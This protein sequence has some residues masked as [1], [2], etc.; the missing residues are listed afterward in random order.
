MFDEHFLNVLTF[1]MLLVVSPAHGQPIVCVWYVFDEH[2]LNVLTFQ[3]LLMV[4]IIHGGLIFCIWCGFD[5]HYL[6][7]LTFQMLLVVSPAHVPL[8][9][10]VLCVFDEHFLNYSEA[11][12][13]AVYNHLKL[14]R[15]KKGKQYLTIFNLICALCAHLSKVKPIIT[16]FFTHLLNF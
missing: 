4:G 15:L 11:P 5:E 16:I 6:N 8:I 7:V 9:F 12:H 13:S 2:F 1:Q 10:C 14:W 3:M